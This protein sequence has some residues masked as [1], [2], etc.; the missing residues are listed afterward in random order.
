MTTT[1]DQASAAGTLVA[2][3]GPRYAQIGL[4]EKGS[5]GDKR[6]KALRRR[7]DKARRFPINTDPCS[8]HLHIMAD[9]LSKGQPYPMLQ[10]EPQHCAESML[11]VLACLWEGRTSD[12]KDAERFRFLQSIDPVSAQAF[13]WNHRSS[14][15]R[16]KAIDAAIIAA[17]V[18]AARTLPETPQTK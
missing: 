9:Y 17:A 11:V 18:A 8:R 1:D 12:G 6:I 16:A 14:K 13:W 15:A 4:Y 7:A 5:A 3:G 2:A 10:E